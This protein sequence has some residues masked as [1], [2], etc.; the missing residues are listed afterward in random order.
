MTQAGVGK[1]THIIAL[2]HG[3]HSLLTLPLGDNLSCVLHNNLIRLKSAITSDA[4]ASIWSLNDLDSY[5]VLATG[6]GSVL[7]LIEV[8]VTTLWT[9]S[10]VAVVT[11]VEHIAV[12]TVL[13]ATSFFKAHASR[14]LQVLVRFPLTSSIA[15]KNI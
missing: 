7:E 9:Q 4:I 6:L 15:H 11:L 1:D 5:I 8:A 14:K 2:V 10:T 3:P 13:V 12:L